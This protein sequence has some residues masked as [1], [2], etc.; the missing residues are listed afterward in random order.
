MR[1]YRRIRF[2]STTLFRH[3]RTWL[4]QRSTH[5]P[6]G[7]TRHR[8]SVSTSWVHWEQSITTLETFSTAS[9]RTGGR[10]NS[11]CYN[12]SSRIFRWRNAKWYSVTAGKTNTSFPPTVLLLLLMNMHESQ[13]RRIKIAEVWVHFSQ[14]T[15]MQNQAATGTGV[16]GY[17]ATGMGTPANRV[18]V[19]GW[20]F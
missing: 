14:V 13:T 8:T 4:T 5:A 7:Y 10:P 20:S 18:R 12:R 16:R 6:R 19:N 17:G 2:I 15:D 3:A 1:T 11:R 9:T